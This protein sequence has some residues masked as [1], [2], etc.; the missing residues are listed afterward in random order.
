MNLILNARYVYHS[1]KGKVAK[2]DYHASV[3]DKTGLEDL[4]SFSLRHISE[5]ALL[6]GNRQEQLVTH[7]QRNLYPFE[8]GIFDALEVSL[9]A[10]ATRQVRLSSSLTGKV[11]VHYVEKLVNELHKRY[12]K[13]DIGYVDFTAKDKARLEQGGYWSGRL[14]QHIRSRQHIPLNLYAD[15][16]GPALTLLLPPGSQK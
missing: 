4:F 2:P 8:L 10:G 1:L 13:D 16:H 7:Y 5:D 14:W 3:P 11:I 9:V 12:G 15:E 6:A